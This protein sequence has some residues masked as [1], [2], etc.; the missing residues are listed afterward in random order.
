[1]GGGINVDTQTWL[2]CCYSTVISY[3]HHPQQQE[4][5]TAA[6]AVAA[7]AVYQQKS[8]FSIEDRTTA[9]QQ[10]RTSKHSTFHHIEQVLHTSL[11][12]FLHSTRY[13]D[14]LNFITSRT[15]SSTYN[16]MGPSF[17]AVQ[18]YGHSKFLPDS[19]RCSAT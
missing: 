19:A 13:T 2:S 7:A 1:M 10:Q 8:S 4:K 5:T 12:D 16:V 15:P 14:L 11:L 9:A 3:N 18:Y 17:F 6:V